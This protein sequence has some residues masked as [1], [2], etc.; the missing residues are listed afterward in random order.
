M[1]KTIQLLLLVG[2]VAISAG[3]ATPYMADRGRDAADIFTATIG[4]GGGAR[5]R[6][7]PVHAGVVPFNVG[8]FG[9]R[10]GCWDNDFSGMTYTEQDFMIIPL[11]EIDTSGGEYV[12]GFAVTG[13]TPDSRVATERGKGFYAGSRIPF[14]TTD[15]SPPRD[16]NSSRHPYSY[17]TQLEATIGVGL[18]INLGFNPG[19]LFDFLLG[20]TTLDVFDDDIEQKESNK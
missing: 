4:V 19:E 11:S 9:L 16:T 3:C 15:V 6:V 17:Y 20:W 8:S 5:A 2:L 10:G 1:K 14:I 18:T 7:G 13:Y 12:R